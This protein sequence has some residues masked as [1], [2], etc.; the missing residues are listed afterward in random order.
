M[1]NLDRSFGKLKMEISIADKSWDIISQFRYE[2]LT[3][4]EKYSGISEHDLQKI[5]ADL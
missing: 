1:K 4:P 5:G 2:K 3:N